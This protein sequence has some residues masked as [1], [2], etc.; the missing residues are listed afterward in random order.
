MPWVDIV[1]AVAPSIIGGLFGSN[2]SGNQYSGGGQ[3]FY[4]PTGQGAADTSWQGAFNSANDTAK[5]VNSQANPLYQNT[6][7]QQQGIN[8]QPYQQAANQAGQA[9]GQASQAAGQNAQQYG[10]QAQQAQG[11]ANQMYGA[12]NQI[13]AQAFDPNNAQ[14]NQSQQ[15]MTDQVRAGQAARG[16]GNSQAG[17]M[18]ENQANKNFDI[19]WN[20]QRLQ[21]EQTGI[22]GMTQANH[23][24]GAQGVFGNANMDAQLGAYNNQGM[25]GQQAQQAPLSAQQYVAGQPAANANGYSQNMA[26]SN[27]LYNQVQ[28]QAIPY[29]N[30][31]NSSAQNAYSAF[32]GQQTNNQNNN[33]AMAK[34]ITGAFGSDAGQR[35]MQGAG[36]W[37]NNNIFGGS[38]N[39]DSSASGNTGD[40]SGQ[41]SYT[42]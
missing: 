8:Y 22:Q 7:N 13:Y 15:Q 14:F 16:L 40:Y 10:Q 29:M 18:E 9:Y 6:L 39:Y 5:N 2:S 41:T 34:T 37:L 4:Q 1:S 38:P 11:Q 27:G 26:V 36:S 30:Y 25:Y 42:A 12:G 24:G 20:T 28:N 31:G 23:A 32:A 3:P 35:A 19:A 21:N 33:A 17:A